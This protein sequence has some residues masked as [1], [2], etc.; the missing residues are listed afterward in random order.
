MSNTG[1]GQTKRLFKS[2]SLNVFAPDYTD[3]NRAFG[4]KAPTG[5][6]YIGSKESDPKNIISPPRIVT[7]KQVQIHLVINF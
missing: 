1:R 4:L 5:N 7:G 2:L 6:Y 3:N